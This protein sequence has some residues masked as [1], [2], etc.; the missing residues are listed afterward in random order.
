MHPHGYNLYLQGLLRLIYHTRDIYR[1]YVQD[2]TYCDLLDYRPSQ[3]QRQVNAFY[4]WTTLPTQCP[5]CTALSY[6]DSAILGTA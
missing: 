5:L 3:T 2:Q 1:C 4:V 6:H